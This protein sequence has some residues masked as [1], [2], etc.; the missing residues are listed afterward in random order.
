MHFLDEVAKH[1]LGDFKIGDNTVFDWPDRIDITR[2][3]A[4]HLFC[5]LTN[6]QH[7]AHSYILPDGHN[8]GFTQN[9]SLSLDI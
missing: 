1:R 4:E 7:S 8:R 9:N 3:L 5:F 6:G 2:R